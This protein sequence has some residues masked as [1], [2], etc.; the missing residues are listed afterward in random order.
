MSLPVDTNAFLTTSFSQ[1][2]VSLLGKESDM[3]AVSKFW[4]LLCFLVHAWELSF[5]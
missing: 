5:E 3:M 2:D 1:L 4:P